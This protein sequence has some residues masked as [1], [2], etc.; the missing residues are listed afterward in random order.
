[1]G[2][3]VEDLDAL[4]NTLV[5]ELNDEDTLGIALFGSV[6]RGT[7]RPDSDIDLTRFVAARPTDPDARFVLVYREHRLISI[8]TEGMDGLGSGMMRPETAVWAVPAWRQARLL[9]DPTGRLREVQQQAR[10]FR[11]EPLQP[12]ADAFASRRLMKFA[13]E[14]HTLASALRREDA[15]QVVTMT[16]WLVLGLPRV[17]A[18]QRGLLLENETKESQQVQAALGHEAVWSRAYRVAAGL[19]D[20]PAPPPLPARGRAAL[21]LYRETVHLLDPVLRPAH[22]EVVMAVLARIDDTD[23][24]TVDTASAT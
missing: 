6:S 1:M 5:E 13:E 14:A 18:V 9:A 20:V 15:A 22:R 8:M 3:K 16:T 24:L 19:D 23:V 10:A 4:L 2:W 7:A 17:V 12:A 21:R 11:W